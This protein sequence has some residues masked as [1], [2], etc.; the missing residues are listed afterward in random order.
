M[1]CRIAGLDHLVDA[2]G[3]DLAVLHGDRAK[4]S[5]ARFD[6]AASKGDGLAEKTLF[7]VHVPS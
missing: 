4:G 1:R 2:F 6:V 3:D 7:L 5:A